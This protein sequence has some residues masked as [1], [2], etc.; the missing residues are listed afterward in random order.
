VLLLAHQLGIFFDAR[1]LKDSFLM[2]E[3][4]IWHDVAVGVAFWMVDVAL[5]RPGVM[6]LPYLGISAYAAL[7]V[8]V[9]WVLSS[10]LTV[11]MWRA[12]G[13]ALAD[14][15]T[16][17]LTP[18]NLAGMLVVLVAAMILPWLMKGLT[19]VERNASTVVVLAMAAI[20]PLASSRVET[21]GLHR[22]AI[23]ALIATATPRI[24]A[25]A[26]DADWRA[27]PVAEGIGEDLTHFRGAAAGRNVVIVALE[28][29]GAQY[30]AFHGADRDPAPNLTEMAAKSLVFESAYVTYPESIKGLF[31]LLCSRAPAF[32]VP[33]EDHAR[34][35]CAPLPQV[36]GAKGFRTGLFHSGRFGYLGMQG[37]VD[38]Q[39]FETAEDAGAIGGNVQSSFGVDEP[40]TVAR[41]LAWIDRGKSGRFLLTYLPVAGHHPRPAGGRPG[42]NR[43]LL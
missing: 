36:L 11:P 22:N 41:M 43:G 1:D 12:S 35:S 27:S 16:H 21:H 24:A 31:A 4:L 10:P 15:V 40:A 39:G 33:T 26:A 19:A 17:Y 38:Q 28:S 23:T 37:I 32:D 5:R 18:M 42:W 3:A 20:G 13:G 9:V 30:L 8:P 14:S 6:W 29:M 34:A 25:K 7:N 2:P